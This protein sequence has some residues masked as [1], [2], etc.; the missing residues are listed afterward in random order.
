MSHICDKILR[1]YTF[2]RSTARAARN[3]VRVSYIKIITA[4]IV[5]TWSSWL[6]QPADIDATRVEFPSGNLGLII[7]IVYVCVS[8]S[9]DLGFDPRFGIARVK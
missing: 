3:K 6:S 9:K 8:K 2:S 1:T 7:W 4:E 5:T